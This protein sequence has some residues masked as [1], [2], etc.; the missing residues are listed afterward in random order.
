[1][2]T[3]YFFQLTSKR[4]EERLHFPNTIISA[5]HTKGDRTVIQLQ[6]NDTEDSVVA[7]LVEMGISKENIR[8]GFIHPKNPRNQEDLKQES[9]I[10][11]T[12]TT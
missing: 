3:L 6:R 7:E 9:V 2:P 8:L 5:S 11:A 12:R 4:W 1:M 10:V